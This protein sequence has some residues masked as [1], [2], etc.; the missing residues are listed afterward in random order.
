M[1]GILK[2]TYHDCQHVEREE[3][4]GC[5]RKRGVERKEERGGKGK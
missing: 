5:G 3:G 2:T 1:G 4:E